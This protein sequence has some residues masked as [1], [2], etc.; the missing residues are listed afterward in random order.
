MNI[1]KNSSLV[2]DL[3][4]TNVG[5]SIDKLS[6][7]KCLESQMI[8]TVNQA[9]RE[10]NNRLCITLATVDDGSAPWN[11]PVYSASDP[12][13]NFYWMSSFS[14]QHSTNI[15]HNSRTFAVVYDSAAPEGT[16]FGVY[17]RGNYTN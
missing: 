3:L 5:F 4:F 7:Q 14:S 11:A 6:N 15:R 10:I 2:I 13:Y 8:Q 9:K 1:V 17:L 12:K 16:G